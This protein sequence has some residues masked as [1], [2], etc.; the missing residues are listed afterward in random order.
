[1]KLTIAIEREWTLYAFP[2][3]HRVT[4]ERGIELREAELGQLDLVGTAALARENQV[5]AEKLRVA[6]LELEA[7]KEAISDAANKNVREKIG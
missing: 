5:L 2:A 4:D 3:G 1:M 6:E 7:L